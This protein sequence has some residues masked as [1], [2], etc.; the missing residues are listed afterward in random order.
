MIAKKKSTGLPISPKALLEAIGLIEEESASPFELALFVDVSV[1]PALLAYAKEA[2]RPQTGSLSITVLPYSDEGEDIDELLSSLLEDT[3][4]VLLA[5]ESALTGSLLARARE[6]QLSAV[7]V[8]LDP[9]RLQQIARDNHSEID[10]FSIVT[11]A[12]CTNRREADANARSDRGGH[13]VRDDIDPQ[14]ECFARLFLALG[15]WIVRRLP[16]SALSLARA[17][18]FV[19]GPF[20]AS[21]TQATSLQ[22]AAIAAVFFLPGADMPLLTLNQMKLF[23]KIATVYD[24]TLDRQRLQELAVLLLGGFGFRALARRLVGVVPVLGWAIRGGI[25]YTGTLAVGTAAHE[26]FERGGDLKK[27]LRGFGRG[28][29][30]DDSA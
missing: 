12:E 5:A 11:A 22:N 6:R 25:G 4:V 8:T 21:I 2:C 27:L 13:C 16:D 26:Y 14:Q 23:L 29:A 9:V 18:C 19:R 7:V 15:E 1:D 28:S 20:I 3:L 17:L 30:T 10:V 24:V